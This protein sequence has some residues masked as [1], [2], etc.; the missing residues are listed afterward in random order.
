VSRR[1]DVAAATRFFEMM[2]TGYER[3]REVT[4]DRAAPLLRVVDVVVPGAFHET[5]EYANNRVECDLGRL[6]ARVG[7]MR[8]L[9]VDW[10]ASMVIRGHAFV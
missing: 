4:T 5:A 1:R 8:G 2:L 3:P 7:P 10:T 6:K 9:G